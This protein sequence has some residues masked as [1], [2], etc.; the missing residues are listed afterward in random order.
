MRDLILKPIT[1]APDHVD[2]PKVRRLFGESYSLA[3]DDLKR[4]QE[5]TEEG[6]RRV[7]VAERA[8]RRKKVQNRL[9]SFDFTGAL[10]VSNKSIDA[11]IN[12]NEGVLV[13]P[14]SDPSGTGWGEDPCRRLPLR[15]Q[16]GAARIALHR[17][18]LCAR[19]RV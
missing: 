3:V 10:L 9:T 16:V 17:A 13:L 8:E 12:L 5:G 6:T 11:C 1:E 19:F 2:L 4:R 14:T 7:G 15:T 18:C